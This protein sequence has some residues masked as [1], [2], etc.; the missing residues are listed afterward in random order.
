MDPENIY[1]ADTDVDITD[2]EDDVANPVPVVN[3]I[4]FEDENGVFYYHNYFFEFYTE[5]M[6]NKVESNEEEQYELI[7]Q[8][9]LIDESL[10]MWYFIT[11]LE[12]REE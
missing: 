6:N 10:F 2:D 3:Y 5:F 7:E 4:L 9:N 12:P 1:N 11:S 8:Q